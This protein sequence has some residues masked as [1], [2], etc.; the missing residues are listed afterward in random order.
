MPLQQTRL[1]SG[2]RSDALCQIQQAHAEGVAS[3]YDHETLRCVSRNIKHADYRR[4]DEIL[5]TA[6]M[7]S[8]YGMFVSKSDYNNWD[9]HH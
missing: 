4:S 6:V 3:H 9:H 5:V 2:S 1:R 8:T 7:I